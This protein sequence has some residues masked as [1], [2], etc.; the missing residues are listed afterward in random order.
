MIYSYDR[1]IYFMTWDA[2]ADFVA[3]FDTTAASATP[4]AFINTSHISTSGFGKEA[5]KY[6][7]IEFDCAYYVP[8]GC[9]Y[10][11]S[12][13]I[14]TDN[15]GNIDSVNANNTTISSTGAITVGVSK[16]IVAANKKYLLFTEDDNGNKYNNQIMVSIT[17]MGFEKT[18]KA[19]AY[20]VYKDSNNELH[21]VYSSG[22]AQVTTPAWNG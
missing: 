8:S 12:G 22:T 9:T 2:P 20:L 6:H 21:V 7:K 3:V 16:I 10:V 5:N 14:Y 11:S 19:R 1:E 13:I 18:R 4:T 15:T 17:N